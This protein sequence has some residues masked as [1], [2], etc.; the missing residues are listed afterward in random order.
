MGKKLVAVLL[1]LAIGLALLPGMTVQTYAAETTVPDGA[2]TMTAWAEGGY[3]DVDP[4]ALTINNADD[5]KAFQTAMCTYG[6]TFVG[7]EVY[8][9]ADLDMNPDWSSDV[10]LLYDSGN[11]M[12]TDSVYAATGV[13]DTG[14][15]LPSIDTT[16]DGKLK[17]PSQKKKFGGVFDGLGHSISGL[18]LSANSSS[19][20]GL[21]GQVEGT[22][23]EV[24][25]LAVLDAYF[26][27]GSSTSDTVHPIGGLFSNV[28]SGAKA[29]IAN[30]YVDVDLC[31]RFTPKSKRVDGKL[32]GLV[33]YCAGTLEI[34]DSVY[35]GSVSYYYNADAAYRKDGVGGAVGLV[36]GTEAAPASVT[37]E[38]FV[39]TGTVYSQYQRVSGGIGRS[40]GYADITMKNCLSLGEV[41]GASNVAALHSSILVESTSGGKQNV[42]MTDCYH[43]GNAAYLFVVA[44]AKNWLDSTVTVK[45]NGEEK[46]TYKLVDSTG[47]KT[48]STN[49]EVYLTGKTNEAT[50]EQP[51]GGEG[52]ETLGSVYTDLEGAIVPKAL[53]AT[54]GENTRIL[55]GESVSTW[56]ASGY[57]DLATKVLRIKTTEDFKAFQ[58]AMCVY[59]KTFTEYTVYLTNDL[60]FNS[61]WSSPV[62]LDWGWSYLTDGYGTLSSNSVQYAANTDTDKTKVPVEDNVKN[63]YVLPISNHSTNENG[64]NKEFNGTFEGMGHSI[65]GL[66]LTANSGTAGALFGRVTGTAAVNDLAVLNSYIDNPH[67]DT[68][69]SNKNPTGGLFSVVNTGATANISNCY[70]DIDLYDGK[71][72]ASTATDGSVGGLVG[73]CLGTLNVNDSVYAGSASIK[74]TG[75]NGKRGLGGAV[76]FAE[77]ATI[78]MTNFTFAGAA[79][80]GYQRVSGG[81][82]RVQGASTVTMN[83]CL[84]IGRIYAKSAVAGLIG[85]AL[86][87]T[88]QNITLNDC[89]T[90]TNDKGYLLVCAG[91]K[92]DGCSV[93]VNTNNDSQFDLATDTGTN[94]AKEACKVYLNATTRLYS[95]VG[96]ENFAL[97]EAPYGGG[98][99]Q[100]LSDVFTIVGGVLAPNSLYEKVLSNHIPT[101]LTHKSH[102]ISL[103]GNIWINKYAYFKDSNKDLSG[104]NL[105]ANA[106]LLIWNNEITEENAIY[107]GKDTADNGATN[108]AGLIWAPGKDA[109]GQS[110]EGIAAPLYGDE[111]YMREYVQVGDGYIYGDLTSF[112]VK[113]YCTSVIQGEL[114]KAEADRDTDLMK[115]CAAVLNYGAAAQKKF[116]HNVENLVNAE[117]DS[118]LTT[119]FVESMLKE[120]AAVPT[121]AIT[122]SGIV[123]KVTR[124]ISLDEG[125]RINYYFKPVDDLD[126]STI[127]SA[128]LLTWS[129][130]DGELTYENAKVTDL[131]LMS[132]GRYAASGAL[133]A[134]ADCGD[135]IYACAR[136]VDAEGNVSHTEVTAYSAHQYAADV[137]A[138]DSEK[139]ELT[140]DA[141]KALVVYS[142]LA[143]AYFNA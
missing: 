89:Y 24:R 136:F 41:Y 22:A 60:V 77:N 32:G 38:N 28:P 120:L 116:D 7:Y 75:G 42:T 76:G 2:T 134:A 53:N 27:N 143:D 101:A 47:T 33:G 62:H 118:A 81:I 23:A 102:S 55:V 124:S 121:T 69:S 67:S 97:N 66:Y 84:N 12:K 99:D 91:T 51:I 80:C 109:Y 93:K 20:L 82:G 95:F 13:G 26:A 137:L 40:Q 36:E 14:Y 11:L 103:E 129:G 88:A 90:L 96:G 73:K 45:V 46:Y 100:Y 86:V 19:V 105:N 44:G 127:A 43:N 64:K 63:Y 115:L 50:L 31:D 74:Y 37:M 112:S 58:T 54:F 56:A 119:A 125:I 5:F 6:Q 34:K 48:G 25:N 110:T 3:A 126:P 83:R 106:G 135:T 65:S 141:V 138:L 68:A 15:K 49:D 113:D 139:Y 18:Y 128:E 35:A 107:G 52:T 131:T 98:E 123:E 85:S 104:F 57:T 29:I 21:L 9:T 39:F 4:M 140:Q 117:I 132:D 30:C 122:D 72:P 8:L 17:N 130:V 70:V 87:E 78:N 59:G 108:Q 111:L 133:V 10:N 79:Y 61:G 1:A 142:H 16:T 94:I 92:I 114:A 71:A